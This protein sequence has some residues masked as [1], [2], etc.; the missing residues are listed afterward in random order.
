MENRHL[1]SQ[2]YGKITSIKVLPFKGQGN[3]VEMEITQVAEFKGELSGHAIG[4]NYVRLAPDG[5]STTRF[6]GIL[7]SDEGETVFLSLQECQSPPP[8]ENHVI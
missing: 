4:S 6:Y 8:V 1:V 3:P 5:S 7:T 2:Y